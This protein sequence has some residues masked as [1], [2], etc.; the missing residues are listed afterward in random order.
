VV[1]VVVGFVVV[2]VGVV[3]VV[4]VVGFVVVVV[5]VVVV[6]VVGI[7]FPQKRAKE[8]VSPR[9]MFEKEPEVT[10][11]LKSISALAD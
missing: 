6:V 10:A 4:V 1:V 9:P 7:G 5:G 11:G 2:V 3:V 8:M